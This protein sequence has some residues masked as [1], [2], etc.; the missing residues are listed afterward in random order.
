MPRTFAQA[1][2]YIVRSLFVGRGVGVDRQECVCVFEGGVAEER[3]VGGQAFK[4]VKEKTK[5][6]FGFKVSKYIL[7]SHK[8]WVA[9]SF[10]SRLLYSCKTCIL[11]Y[12]KRCLIW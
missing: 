10:L 9:P 11:V 4:T 8:S 12:E 7:V 5:R 2:C 6:L 3:N 1:H